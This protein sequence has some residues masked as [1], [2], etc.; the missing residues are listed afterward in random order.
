MKLRSVGIFVIK[1]VIPFV[2]ILLLI[3]VLLFFL[4]FDTLAQSALQEATDGLPG[5]ITVKKFS[6]SFS[7]VKMD[8]FRWS[9][10]SQE[11][12]FEAS[13]ISVDIA[14]REVFSENKERAL[15]AIHLKKPGLR[16]V[17]SPSGELNLTKL[18]PTDPDAEPIDISR[19]RSKLTIDD[20]WLIYKDQRRSGFLYEF[21]AWQGEF[22]LP[23]G[24][25]L[26][27][28]NRAIPNGARESELSAKG[29]ISLTQPELESEIGF[30]EFDLGSLTGFPGFGPGR[31]SVAG[32][33]N[34]SVRMTGSEQTWNE[35]LTNAFF[36]GDLDLRDGAFQS[37]SMSSPLRGLQGKV[38]LL[39]LDISTEQL[40]GNLGPIAFSAKGHGGF[41]EDSKIEGELQTSRFNLRELD[42]Y[43]TQALPVAGEMELKARFEQSG[44][45]ALPILSGHLKGYDLESQGQKVR[46]GSL[47][48]LKSENLLYLSDIK[49]SSE[50]GE[51][52][53]EGWVFLG[54]EPRVLFD[55]QGRDA[56]PELILP[57]LAQR[58][59]FDVKLMGSPEA[60]LLYGGGSLLGLGV[61]AQGIQEADG[62]FVFSGDNLVVYNGRGSLG[63]SSVSLPVG[64]M[65]ISQKTFTGIVKA[66]NYRAEDLPGSSGLQGSFSGRALVNADLA[67]SVPFVEAQALVSGANLYAQGMSLEGAEAL[68]N[69][70]GQRL[71][72][73]W[74]KAQVEGAE[75]ELS[76]D[77]DPRTQS[78]SLAATSSQFDMAALGL[79]SE[80]VELLGSIEGR[81]D[82][83]LGL[84]GVA[85][86]SRGNVA[87]SAYKTSDG[88]VSGVAW[89]DGR[90]AG[91]DVQGTVVASGTPD[92]ME[93]DYNAF[94]SGER[95]AG[96]GP[97]DLTGSALVEGSTLTLRPTLLSS[98]D[99]KGD[100]QLY[101]VTAYAGRAFSFFG[102]LMAGPLD[103][104]IIE[105][106]PFPTGRSLLLSGATNLE[107]G[108]LDLDFQLRSAGLEELAS[109]DYTGALPFELLSGFGRVDGE[110][111]GTLTA[112][113]ISG[114]FHFPWL[115]LGKGSEQR[116]PLSTRG[117]FALLN[118]TLRVPDML[119]SQ[120]PFDT[121]LRTKKLESQRRG[122][123]GLQGFIDKGNNFD[124]RVKTE[125]FTSSFFAF[126]AEPSTQ[127]W[128]P[129]GRLATD[130]LHLWGSL[131]KPSVAGRVD[132]L[133]GGLFLAEKP[134]FLN[135]AFIDMSSQDEEIS[136][137]EL[138]VLAPGF[139]LKGALKKRADGTLE[140]LLSAD[141][142]ELRKLRR[143]GSFLPGLGGKADLRLALGGTF[144]SEPA[145]EIG[146]RTHE[147]TWNPKIL[148]GLD[149]IVPIEQF[150][151][152][153]FDE[154][155]SQLVSGLSL[156]FGESALGVE[157][158]KSGFHFRRGEGGLEV[159]VS[160]A[161]RLPQ[162]ISDAPFATFR[163]I[164][165][166][167][168]SPEGPDFGRSGSPFE[169]TVSGLSTSEM[170]LLTGTQKGE[171]ELKTSLELSLEGQW[172][173]DH[174]LK[175]G[176][177]LP[178]Y[179]LTFHDLALESVDTEG[180]LSGMQL[181]TSASLDYQRDG[182]AGFLE[183]E[184]W[185]FGFFWEQA[186]LE[187]ETKRSE[188]TETDPEDLMLWQ[189]AIDLGGRL[190]LT[191][192]AGDNPE[193][194]LNIG[195]VDIPLANL[196][197]LLPSV[198][199][200]DGLLE[201]M[202][203]NLSGTLPSPDLTVAGLVSGLQ[204]GNL[205]NMRLNA[206][207]SGSQG[208]E[209]YSLVL[210][211]KDKMGLNLSFEDNDPESH[212]V[213]ASGRADL[214]WL[215]DEKLLT[216]DRLELFG[217]NL[218]L[219]PD[220][221]LDF[222][223]A[224]IDK[225]LK[226]LS[227]FVS[228][229]ET[230][231][232]TLQGEL[233]ATGT[234]KRPELAGE[235]TLSDGQFLS[236]RFG[237]FEDLN[238]DLEISQSNHGDFESVASSLEPSSNILTKFSL[239]QFE[240]LLGQ[241]PFFGGGV[242]EFS[243]FAPA[244]LKMFL[245]GEALPVKIPD[246]FT[247]TVDMDFDLSG[248]L[249]L[250]D[251]GP[252]LRPRLDGIISIPDGDFYVPLPSEEPVASETDSSISP[253]DVSLE[254]SLGS[255]FFAK[256][257]NS[258]VRAVGDLKLTTESGTPEVFGELA[259]SR[260]KILIP[261]YNS[262]FKIG[263]GLAK[264]DGPL[265]PNLEDV[266]AVAE[267]GDYQVTARANGRYPDSFKLKLFS[268]PPLSD[269]E[270]SQI[271]VSGGLLDGSEEGALNRLSDS[272]VSFLSGLLTRKLTDKLES[273]LFLSELSIDFVPP[274]TFAIKLAKSLSPDDTVLLTVTRIIRESGLNDNLFGVEWRFSRNFL[275]RVAFDQ[276]S[277]VRFWLQSIN[278]F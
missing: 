60:P 17:V 142:I 157:F 18:I 99:T 12:V 39:G 51:L 47:D 200:S 62:R 69:Y 118:E 30:Q 264:F 156:I 92:S 117:S 3:L 129:H 226:V 68:L 75:L 36:L 130:S 189:G 16:V 258:E 123:L 35:L 29:R 43:L 166:H 126:F 85:K 204:V 158:P 197:P 2:V 79:P 9:I 190:A 19:F 88:N 230:A 181:D 38:S 50:L 77:F 253:V 143:F 195:A 102:P 134:F 162:R 207:L 272:G 247:G 11:P 201:F 192:V 274:A 21:S 240:G 178:H 122:L 270:L 110:L 72:V 212:S 44:R 241:Q 20:G 65:D 148:G 54:A 177:T 159:D 184:D 78:V 107:S 276:L 140:G 139:N 13:E 103:K 89:V 260:G 182:R 267:I 141:E 41:R 172:W 265:V 1:R 179:R 4:F 5:R 249:A 42:P 248:Y 61:W 87:V 149:Q 242:A 98:A 90:D 133:E 221:T 127:R 91:V 97:L 271:A 145:V 105:E 7:G 120:Y 219:S 167:L 109:A 100:A 112:P 24:K 183:L 228:G 57:G 194:E 83:E 138:A 217:K 191:K 144:P 223:G 151:L 255:D 198:A 34:G 86:A 132:L 152:G 52:A 136:V 74:A 246:L 81:L 116:L 23:D 216:S 251:Q 73:P 237:K 231:K 209:V 66:Q 243:G 170:A 113:D 225:D 261:F 108:E 76:G 227:D 119:I 202:E 165:D 49:A 161:V 6:P 176:S 256:A 64:F 31:T 224:V 45:R 111:L 101:P 220:S 164:A 218:T 252:V 94:L 26:T 174:H 15:R 206:F 70:D 59:D 210:G 37:P 275:T 188:D 233:L 244:Y 40:K 268:N 125:T 53:G 46:E 137:N 213:R 115:F 128:I 48:F 263:Q 163:E 186:P 250:T 222:K 229:T 232:G 131:L 160:G 150:V 199:F 180:L 55:I 114:D 147:L 245:V 196:K 187:A 205:K 63:G 193:S 14:F 214:R 215:A 96:L 266:E 208:D 22:S 33:L 269:A 171:N 173:R 8:A 169:L 211:G 67:Q 155:S 236:D 238:L 154:D 203:L 262:V 239:H 278:R 56:K 234:L 32:T 273:L 175:A 235:L 257:L 259:L 185:Q 95:L 27:L 104:M 153:H 82:G 121:R 135:S 58:A 84:Y 71:S 254:L 28:K 124:L 146:V 168:V 25:F 106:S 80:Q 93:V 277:R 10:G